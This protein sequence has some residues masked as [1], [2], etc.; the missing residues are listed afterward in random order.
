MSQ[1][2][3][4][5]LPAE[6]VPVIWSLGGGLPSAGYVPAKLTND[7]PADP[8]KVD[9]GY[10]FLSGVLQA[11]TV[12]ACAAIIH[13]NYDPGIHDI[14]L[15]AG[16]SPGAV[17]YTVPFP[18][19]P[20][21]ALD[22]YPV[23]LFLDLRPLGPLPVYQYWYV[24]SYPGWGTYTTNSVPISIGELKLYT[25]V[26]AIDGSLVLDLQPTETEG[27][28]IIDRETDGDVS[29]VY[30]LGTKRRFLRGG[31]LQAGE[32]AAA[33]QRWYRAARGRTLPFV[34]LVSDAEGSET[35]EPW[36]CRWEHPTLERRFTYGAVASTFAL[37]IEEISRG[38]RPTPM[39]MLNAMDLARGNRRW[40]NAF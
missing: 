26:H 19:V 16:N 29:L 14:Y 3:E 4:Y 39:P 22:G 2:L 12:V 38:L 18:T 40:N 30:P 28:P 7:N 9:T 33:L 31:V 32:A 35:T 21:L 17:S 27:Y 8:Y 34:V 36:L 37:E 6:E 13:H 11:P 10:L 15:A 24:I 1:D 20:P 5:T 23:N 25:S